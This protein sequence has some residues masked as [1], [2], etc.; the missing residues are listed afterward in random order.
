MGGLWFD[1]HPHHQNSW[2]SNVL[3]RVEL[4]LGRF[5]G[6]VLCK[7]GYY[8]HILNNCHIV[9]I[10]ILAFERCFE[11]VNTDFVNCVHFSADCADSELDN[12]IFYVQIDS[13]C[14]IQ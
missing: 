6:I 3:L 11:V 1:V 4:G 5:G 12:H 8:P 14:D 10:T 2:M 9:C 7:R 13:N